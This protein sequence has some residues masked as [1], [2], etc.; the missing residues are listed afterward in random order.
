MKPTGNRQK[1]AETLSRYLSGEM[2]MEESSAFKAAI[3]AVPDTRKAWNKLHS[4][5]QDEKLI[6]ARGLNSGTSFI[7]PLLKIA[8]VVLILAGLG[9]VAYLKLN[10]KPA[11]EMVQLNT[12]NEANTLVKTLAD[13][14][15]IY[16]AQNSLFSFP[17]EFLSGTR[18]VGL[19]GEAF[20]DVVPSPG[21][22]FIIE[23]EEVL[24]EVLGTAFNVKT[25]NGEGF[26]LSVDRGKVKVTLKADPSGGETVLAGEQISVVKNS[27]V[28]SKFVA[29]EA[30]SW[31]KQR[32]HF[33]DEPLCNIIPVVNRN[34]NTTFVLADSET[35][36]HRLTVT[37]D[38]ETAETITG[39]ICTALNLKSQTINGEIVL[40]ENK[41]GA[42]QR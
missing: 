6:P 27:L 15:V 22:P 2:S 32:M 39:L 37:F 26:K 13:G 16:I 30:S 19:K 21:K 23:T 38:N 8:A 29:G 41:E 40:S 28:K 35:G 7:R 9:A 4:R 12:V 42:K 5:L 25:Q 36:K 20:F 24:I 11:A 3:S 17:Q 34:F 18:Q 10:P 14:S 1:Y 31:Y 33:K